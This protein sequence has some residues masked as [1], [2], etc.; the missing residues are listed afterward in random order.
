VNS[1]LVASTATMRANQLRL[2]FASFTYVRPCALR[3]R[4]LFAKAA[5]SGI[6]PDVYSHRRELFVPHCSPAPGAPAK[7][8]FGE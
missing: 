4:A 7:Q 3:Y 5:V 6:A 8:Q 1:V 2:W